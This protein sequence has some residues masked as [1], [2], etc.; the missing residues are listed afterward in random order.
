MAISYFGSLIFGIATFPGPYDWRTKSMSK[1]LYPATNPQFHSV[2]S[3][4]IAVTGLSMIPLV[5]YVAKRLRHNSPITAFVG[6]LVFCAGALSLSLAGVIVWQPFHEPIARS[7]G[8]CLGLGT[9]VFYLCT[10]QEFSLPPNQRRTP[11]PLFL[12]WSLIVPPALLISLLRLIAGAHFQWSSPLY[13]RLEDRSLWHLGFWEWIIS[14]AVFLFLLAAA[15]F[16]PEQ[17]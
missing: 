14:A 10:L 1:L 17:D 12:A 15:L 7:A 16:L 2:V 11:P 4:G 5:G 9:L 3:A 6:A 8:I 13:Q